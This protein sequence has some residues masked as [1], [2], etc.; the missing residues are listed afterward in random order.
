MRVGIIVAMNKEFDLIAHYCQD[1]E[2]VRH[3]IHEKY[4]CRYMMLR[5]SSKDDIII[6]QCGIGKVNAAVGAMLLFYMNVDCIISSG[7]AGSLKEEIMPGMIVVGTEYRY[8]D[9]YCGAENEQGQIQGEPTT[10]DAANILLDISLRLRAKD[11]LYGLI[12]SGDQ[13]VDKKDVAEHISDQYPVACA[14]DMESCS[15]A[16]VCHKINKPFLSY[17]MISD[18]ILNPTAISYKKFWEEAPSR[19]AKYTL[20]YVNTIIEYIKRQK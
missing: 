5:L 9:V 7:V 2:N 14:I 8:H 16:Q 10:F 1:K 20:S 17:R 13:F 4:G 11:T 12:V 3:A 15:I 6:M 19:M 18:S